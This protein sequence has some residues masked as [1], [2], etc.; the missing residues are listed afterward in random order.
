[1]KSAA[2]PHGRPVASSESP[3]LD[4]IPL[5]LEGE[6]QSR[7]PG[8]LTPE[9]PGSESLRPLLADTD[10][11]G[12][13]VNLRNLRMRASPHPDETLVADFRLSNKNLLRIPGMVVIASRPGGRNQHC[14]KSLRNHTVPNTS[15][16]HREEQNHSPGG[17]R[18]RLCSSKGWEER[19]RK[20]PSHDTGGGTGV[21]AGPQAGSSNTREETSTSLGVGF[22]VTRLT[23][24]S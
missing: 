11:A 18:V 10:P 22:L 16:Q 5:G 6:P 8:P 21:Y 7:R 19:C 3:V 2:G 24:Y 1:M 9:L 12:R 17:K 23:S 13:D 4:F 20:G 14:R 15:G